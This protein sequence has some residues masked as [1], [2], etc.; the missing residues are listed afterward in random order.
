MCCMTWYI[1]TRQDLHQ[2]STMTTDQCH[3]TQF[4]RG[5]EIIIFLIPFCVKD[6][7]RPPLFF[8]E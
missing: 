4:E 3:D 6:H 2:G 8:K 7:S 5:L 1:L